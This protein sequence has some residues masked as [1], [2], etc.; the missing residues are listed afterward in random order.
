MYRE[1]I[2]W[3]RSFNLKQVMS[4]YGTG[5]VGSTTKHREICCQKW[6]FNMIQPFFTWDLMSNLYQEWVKWGSKKCMSSSKTP[7]YTSSYCHECGNGSFSACLNHGILGPFSPNHPHFFVGLFAW[8]I[9]NTIWCFFSIYPQLEIR[10]NRFWHCSR[11]E[12]IVDGR[13][14]A[15]PWM[16]ETLWNHLNIIMG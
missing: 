12:H 6:G 16:V 8:K 2:S 7:M 14:P 4:D 15:P 5:E 3:R 11:E 9:N 13:N 10:D 1:T